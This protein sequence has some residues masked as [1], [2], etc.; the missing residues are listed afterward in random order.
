MNLVTNLLLKIDVLNTI[1]ILLNSIVKLMPKFP[2]IKEGVNEVLI[3]ETQS[4]IEQ[5]LSQIFDKNE[6]TK[7]DSLYAFTFGT[8]QIEIKIIPWHAEDVLVNVFSYLAENVNFSQSLMEELLRL[9]AT[10][11]F[12][13]FGVT[14]DNTVIYT[15]SL[16]GKNMDFSEFLA[17]IQTV[18]MIAD[19]YDERFKGIDYILEQSL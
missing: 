4:K 5:Y 3:Q 10:T 8:V 18:A 12:G 6:I 9:N 16:A 2:I 1:E 11:S 14:I 15:Y 13:S 7:V 19:S 17:A